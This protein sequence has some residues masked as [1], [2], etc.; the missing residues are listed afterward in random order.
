MPSPSPCPSLAIPLLA[1]LVLFALGVLGTTADA[2]VDSRTGNRNSTE[3]GE[4]AGFSNNNNE[5]PTVALDKRLLGLGGAVPQVITSLLGNIAPGAA[6]SLEA[7]VTN[8]INSLAPTVDVTGVQPADG[9]PLLTTGP[10]TLP[11]SAHPQPTAA[12]IGGLVDKLSGLLDSLDPAGASDIIAL[13]TSEAGDLVSDVDDIATSVASLANQVAGGQTQAPAAI[14]SVGGLLGSLDAIVQNIAIDV[15]DNLAAD[16]PAPLVS[17][18]MQVVSSG[19]GDIVEVAD[20]PVSLVADLVEQNLCGIVTLVDGV[21]QTV[22]GLCG[23]MASAVSGEA[24]AIASSLSSPATNTAATSAV[25]SAP[26]MGDQS[27]F[28]PTAGPA[29]SASPFLPQPTTA[30]GA[31]GQSFPTLTDSTTGSRPMLTGSP[32]ISSSIP[33]T[34]SGSFSPGAPGLSLSGSLPMSNPNGNSQSPGGAGASQTVLSNSEPPFSQASGTLDSIGDNSGS[35][36]ST[37]AP[38]DATGTSPS[39]G[40]SPIALSPLPSATAS[41]STTTAGASPTIAPSGTGNSAAIG[42]C[43]TLAT[44]IITTIGAASTVTIQAPC[45]TSSCPATTQ[46]TCDCPLATG[47]SSPTDARGPC[48]GSGY[49][50]D[51]CLDGWFCPPVQTPAQPAPC[52]YGWPC[53]HC[54]GGWFCAPMPTLGPSICS[55]SNRPSTSTPGTIT[56]PSSSPSVTSPSTALPSSPLQATSTPPAGSSGASPLRVSGWGYCGCWADP[57][58]QKALG[59]DSVNLGVPLT[60]EECVQHCMGK[61]FIMAGTESG[62]TCYCGNFLNGTE[63]LNDA[64]CSVPCLGDAFQTCGGSGA[65]S[66]FSPDGKPHGWAS[67]GPQ[68]LAPTITPPEVISLVV[69]G[70]AETLVTTPAVVYP[71]GNVNINQLISSYAPPTRQPF[72]DL[73]S[74]PPSSQT[75]QTTPDNG[76]STTPSQNTPPNVSSV[77]TSPSPI[78]ISGTPGNS[79]TPPDSVSGAGSSTS[80]GSLSSSSSSTPNG[81]SGVAPGHGSPPSSISTTGIGSPPSPTPDDP[82]TISIPSSPATPGEHSPSSTGKNPPSTPAGSVGS[83]P[84]P[85]TPSQTPSGDNPPGSASSTPI[86]GGSEQCVPAKDAS[87]TPTGGFGGNRPCTPGQ[88]PH[89]TPTGNNANPTV[90]GQGQG[91]TS[92]SPTSSSTSGDIN[93]GSPPGKGQPPTSSGQGQVPTTGSTGGSNSTPNGGNPGQTSPSENGGTPV[94]PNP[95]SPSNGGFT[96]GQGQSPSPSTSTG[97]LLSCTPGATDPTCILPGGSTM[98]GQSATTTSSSLP[99]STPC[100][101]GTN[102]PS[103]TGPFG[104]S[105]TAPVH[106]QPSSSTSSGNPSICAAGSTDPSCTSP[107]SGGGANPSGTLSQST[108]TLPIGTSLVPSGGGSVTPGQISP[109]T[110]PSPDTSPGSSTL[111]I[112]TVPTGSPGGDTPTQPPGSTPTTSPTAVEGS[113][114]SPSPNSQTSNTSPNGASGVAPHPMTTLSETSYTYPTGLVPYGSGPSS[115]MTTMTSILAWREPDGAI[116]PS[117]M[118]DSAVNPSDSPHETLAFELHY[119]EAPT[120]VTLS[121][122]ASVDPRWQR[123]RPVYVW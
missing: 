31:G 90:P 60:N 11:L 121:Q 115:V 69:G 66:C 59:L 52:G 94:S 83:T 47:S 63:L 74:P 108:S 56:A 27:S 118:P 50:C 73:P 8:D 25:P 93:P 79:E 123:V 120:T 36:Q 30:P 10:A 104:V 109:G 15:E 70:V 81:A 46:P 91:S 6:A 22:A 40:I 29:V 1:A 112:P 34:G 78:T 97:G 86:P 51:D 35:G 84:S 12:L 103:C 42:Q 24:S 19:L 102:D 54:D 113:S 122:S 88:D 43:Q 76:G 61:G 13:V 17:D 23:D 72:G 87:C 18:L 16:L 101:P 106:G 41:L 119:E 28:N 80:S 68:P 95:M 3:N 55:N 67:A 44:Q 99:S 85:G 107:G 21:L 64:L 53:A 32:Q 20:G 57:P 38:S 100:G 116:G 111:T 2:I 96:P 71:A 7:Q 65:L 62:D 37:A 58:S 48:P 26:S 92:P 5:E 105:L 49:T 33:T 117:T 82:G 9:I 77:S 4:L 98:P 75:A 45:T 89:C 39:R 110:T 14:D 114:T